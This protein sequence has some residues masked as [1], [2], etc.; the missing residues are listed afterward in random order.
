MLVNTIDGVRT[1]T[2]SLPLPTIGI[3]IDVFRDTGNESLPLD[4][5]SA[6]CC[7]VL[8]AALI[9]SAR[10]GGLEAGA[11]AGGEVEGAEARS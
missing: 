8:C 11:C 10:G 4:V 6:A 3:S 2:A 9:R 7:F 5:D 1:I